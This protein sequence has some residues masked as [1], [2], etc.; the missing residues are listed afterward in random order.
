MFAG[1][2]LVCSFVV[3]G[4]KTVH[5]TVLDNY[6]FFVNS[7]IIPEQKQHSSIILTVIILDFVAFLLIFS[8]KF[9]VFVFQ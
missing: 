6:R 7:L 2:L 1:Y 4:R 8:V 3:P 9:L 5:L